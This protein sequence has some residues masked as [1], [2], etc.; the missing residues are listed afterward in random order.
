M[1]PRE[2]AGRT[3]PRIL[4]AE[5]ALALRFII[6]PSVLLELEKAEEENGTKTPFRISG[7]E[8]WD[9]TAPYQ[10]REDF[11]RAIVKA[12]EH[13]INLAKMITGNLHNFEDF[14]KAPFGGIGNNLHSDEPYW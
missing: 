13:L 3:W 6:S 2:Q 7:E 4:R 14:E 12:R 5:T 10:D 1:K 11:L 8:L 9:L